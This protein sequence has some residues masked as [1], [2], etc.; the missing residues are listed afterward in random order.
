MTSITGIPRGSAIQTLEKQAMNAAQTQAKF[1][2][3]PSLGS[4]ISA[5]T[6]RN[7]RISAVKSSFQPATS[8]SELQ[9][10]AI[11]I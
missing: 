8:L 9:L 3:I 2:P 6:P 11:A 7:L 1:C 5:E 4:R 10:E